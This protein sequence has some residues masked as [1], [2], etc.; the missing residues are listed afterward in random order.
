M[1]LNFIRFRHT[2][3]ICRVGI[4]NWEFRNGVDVSS[5]PNIR[6]LL[7]SLLLDGLV[8]F[9]VTKRTVERRCG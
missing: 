8:V 7:V 9:N 5:I 3:N 6:C 1:G 2:E 4:E